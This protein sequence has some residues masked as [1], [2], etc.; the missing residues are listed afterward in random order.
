LDEIQTTAQKILSITGNKRIL[1]FY[2]AMGVGK[3]TLIKAICK[4]LGVEEVV[5]SP[6][7]AI[8]NE[9]FSNEAGPV[10]HF[11][12]YRIKDTAEALDIGIDEYFYSGNFC[13][14]EWPGKIEP[15]LPGNFVYLKICEEDSKRLITINLD[16]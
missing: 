7:F 1:A 15:F 16:N 14:I 10:Y 12:F 5:S 3:T 11:D 2:G 6:T 9:Y 13:F 4:Q 8:I